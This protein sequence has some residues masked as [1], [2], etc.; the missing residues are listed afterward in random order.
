MS[1]SE[2][3]ARSLTLREVSFRSASR[4][5]RTI[6]RTWSGSRRS[7]PPAPCAVTVGLGQARFRLTARIP[8]FSSETAHSASISAS[9]PISWTISG[10]PDS[11][12]GRRRFRRTAGEGMLP[13]TEINGVSHR[14]VRRRRWTARTNGGVMTPSI[15]ERRTREGRRNPLSRGSGSEKFI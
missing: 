11:V 3:P 9:R 8:S 1:G 12:Y 10:R 13:V 2:Y 4:T 6:R 7:A 5:A 15:G 14:S